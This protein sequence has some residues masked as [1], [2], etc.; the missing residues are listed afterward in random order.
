[1]YH[2]ICLFFTLNFH[3]LA[4]WPFHP[5][6]RDP[7]AIVQNQLPSS[8]CWQQR[9][10]QQYCS[11]SIV[12]ATSFPFILLCS[13][14]NNPSPFLVAMIVLISEDWRV[15]VARQPSMDLD[16][17]LLHFLVK[18]NLSCKLVNILQNVNLSSD[19]LMKSISD[20]FLRGISAW[21][22]TCFTK[23]LDVPLTSLLI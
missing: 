12:P 14:S 7:L 11:E 21:E 22:N 8:F 13:S 1:M 16:L 17:W 2:R 9:H 4:L 23:T 10:F 6:N 20:L 5:N 19:L 15:S 3:C 18:F